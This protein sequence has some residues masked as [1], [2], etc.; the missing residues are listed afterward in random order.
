MESPFAELRF[1]A[2][3]AKGYKRLDRAIA[4]IWKMLTVAEHRFRHLKAPELMGVRLPQ[5]MVRRWDSR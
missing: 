1:R 3:A 5:R 2:D 4:V